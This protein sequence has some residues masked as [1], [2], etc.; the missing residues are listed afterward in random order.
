MSVRDAHP[1]LRIFGLYRLLCVPE[2]HVAVICS[3]PVYV[4]DEGVFDIHTLLRILCT[5]YDMI[6]THFES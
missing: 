6:L 2:R 4:E 1:L 3:Y 5:L